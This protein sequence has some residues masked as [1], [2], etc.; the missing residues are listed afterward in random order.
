MNI[1]TSTDLL[2]LSLRASVVNRAVFASGR[3]VVTSGNRVG[4]LALVQKGG[5]GGV[6]GGGGGVLR[7]PVTAAQILAQMGSGR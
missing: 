7:Y 3:V 6:A 2:R 1:N 5:G 4:G